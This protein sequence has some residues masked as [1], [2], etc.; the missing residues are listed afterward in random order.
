[1]WGGQRRLLTGPCVLSPAP[2][3]VSYQ[4]GILSATILYEILLGKATLYALLVSI[5][6]LRAKVRRRA[7]QGRQA[8]GR[9]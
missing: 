4:Q 9:G 8:G 3:A 5:L 7:G 2:A 1:M 6:V